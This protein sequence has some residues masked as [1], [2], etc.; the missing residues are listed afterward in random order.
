L[1]YPNRGD[2]VLATL[3]LKSEYIAEMQT[4]YIQANTNGRL[5]DAS[6]PSISP[7]NRGFLYGDAIYEVWRTFDGVIFAW[8]EHWLRLQKSADAL[9][10][11]ELFS[12]E[13]IF[14]EIS[15]TCSAYLNKSGYRGELYIRL[16]ISR[17][18]GSIGLDIGLADKPEFVIIVQPCPE[19]SEHKRREGLRLTVAK[20]LRRNPV[21][22]LNPAWKTGNYLNN[23]LC[24]REAKAEGSDEVVILNING[25]VTE[26]SVSNLA[27]IQEGALITPPL[28]AGILV[29]ITRSLA[30]KL[31][32]KMGLRVIERAITPD[33]LP[34]MQECMILS[35]TRCIAPVSCIDSVNYKV[36]HETLTH[37]L[38][39]AFLTYAHSSAKAH[40]ELMVL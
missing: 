21:N 1:V 10:M 32:E 37:K 8:E 14:S 19:L 23:I 22:T 13:Y 3:D 24:L 34:S 27:F 33:E 40:P 26:A 12:K 28:E 7:L 20:N 38:N 11:K 25:E 15:R 18:C 5:H 2:F 29:G 17:G 16:Q 4:A 36:G 6:E 31:A 35:T 9:F 30:L 39:E